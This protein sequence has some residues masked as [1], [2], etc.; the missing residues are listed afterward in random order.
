MRDSDKEMSARVEIL[1]AKSELLS[2]SPRSVQGAGHGD[3]CWGTSTNLSGAKIM[4]NW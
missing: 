3:S 4:S 2:D 1:T